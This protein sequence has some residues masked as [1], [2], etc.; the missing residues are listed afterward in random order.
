MN[1]KTNALLQFRSQ[2]I[3]IILKMNVLI[4]YLFILSLMLSLNSDAQYFEL[5]K[6]ES[7]YFPKQS[8]DGT[9]LDGVIG[10]WEWSGQLAIPQPLKNDKT[11][12]VHKLKYSNVRTDLTASSVLLDP[13]LT[14]YYHTL[15]Y[16]LDYIQT[17]RLKWKL[18]L[19]INP[20]LASDFE[21]SLSGEDFLF[22]GT[23]LLMNTKKKKFIYGFGFAYTTRFGRALAVPGGMLKYKTPK[24]NFE[25]WFPDNLL[26][27][28]NTDKS[29]QYG[30][31]AAIDG[32]LFNN[33]NNLLSTVN[34]IID[35]TGYSR[36]NIGPAITLKLKKGININLD[37]GV[38]IARRLEF[39]DLIEET[40]DSSPKSGSFFRIGLS[41]IP[42]K[43]NNEGSSE[44]LKSST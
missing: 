16:S 41:F 40:F 28:F 36:L 10:F 43:K 9:S 8:I 30:L 42:K 34:S 25:L 3:K 35:E 37:G 22:Q 27:M 32:G 26:V 14:K 6:A 12:F 44:N 24:M 13:E 1:C 4:K 31:K 18:T 5:I 21:E 29:F 20:M 7:T 19:N 23:A 33:S 17:L 38:V 2:L 11:I 39:I 15:S